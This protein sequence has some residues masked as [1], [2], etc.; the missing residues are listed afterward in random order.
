MALY[1]PPTSDDFFNLN[2]G[3][4][5]EAPPDFFNRRFLNWMSFLDG[6]CQLTDLVLP[7]THESAT[8]SM[9]DWMTGQ[10][11]TFPSVL[12]PSELGEFHSPTQ[13]FNL[14]GQMLSGVRYFLLNMIN[15]NV[16][17]AAQQAMEVLLNA[18]NCVR[19]APLLT[20]TATESWF[21]QSSDFK[22]T[23]QQPVFRPGDRQRPAQGGGLGTGGWH[24]RPARVVVRHGHRRHDTERRRLPRVI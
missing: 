3:D 24:A 5:D 19:Y 12:Q 15:G 17:P 9:R 10:P 20:G 13:S 7:G 23:E 8:Y 16:V 21:A 18:G 11:G 22:Q 14:L 4:P 2:G 1:A 6:S